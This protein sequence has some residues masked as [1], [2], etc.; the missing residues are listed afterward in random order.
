MSRT[1]QWCDG[2]TPSASRP[3]AP[4]CTDSAWRANAIGCCACSGTTAVPSSMR[5]VRAA[6]QRHHGQ[7]VEV[8][9]HL[10]HPRGVQARGLGPLDVVEQLLD[11]AGHVAALGPDH[12]AKAHYSVHPFCRRQLAHLSDKDVQRRARS[13][14]PPRR[15]RPATSARRPAGWCRRRRPRCRPRRRHAAR[16]RCGPSAPHARR[17]GSKARPA[18]RLPAARSTRCPRCAAGCRCRSPRSPRR[19]ACARRSWRRGHGRRDRVWR[20]EHSA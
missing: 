5:E 7:A 16:R 13:E 9:G 19:A 20:P 4:A 11:L 10:R 18:Q 12:H 3:P 14:T 6:H 2:P 1:I 15:R 8:V 17:T